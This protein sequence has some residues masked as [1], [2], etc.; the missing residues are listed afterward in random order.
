M[1]VTQTHIYFWEGNSLFSQ[2]CMKTD[3]KP[4]QFIS[5]ENIKYSCCEQYMMHKK[6]LMFNDLESAEKIL[7]STN[8][9]EMKA[10]G[11]KVKNF[12]N[13]VWDKKKFD[14]ITNA[15][16]LKFTQ[17][18]SFKEELMRYKNHTFVEASP[19]DCIYGA[20]LHYSDD[21]ILDE[22]NWRDQ[23]LLGKALNRTIWIII[24]NE[25]SK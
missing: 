5:K 23:N 24:S 4:Y 11:R 9:K 1:R 17:N 21:L 14:V 19:Y 15:N 12:D 6:A 16:Y 25:R 22:K 7:N 18:P 10:L 20:G 13:A 3:N 8:P 2:W